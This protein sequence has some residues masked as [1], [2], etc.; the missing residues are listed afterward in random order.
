M[1]ERSSDPAYRSPISPGHSW[2]E[3]SCG[4]R[5]AYP[6]L[7]GDRTCDVVVIGGGFCGLSAAYRLAKGGTSVTLIDAARFGDG[8][9]GRNGGQMGSGQR[10]GA[11]ELE[12]QYGFERS[13]ALWD[14]AED[15]KRTLLD[16]ARD[17]GFDID[18]QPGQLTPMHRQR[19]EKEA[20]EEVSLLRERYGYDAIEW[21]DRD[22]MASALGS[23]HYFGGTRDTGTGHIHPMKAVIGLA[24]AAAKAGAA[25]HEQTAMVS[26]EKDGCALGCKNL[27]RHHPYRTGPA[28]AERLSRGYRR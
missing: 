11:L 7:D 6:P 20:R 8:A 12:Q 1:S 9:S 13:K 23:T 16:T 4:E 18:Y 25:L 24:R 2:Y 19:Y 28:G 14:M 15:A 21:L 3:A 10:A 26:T 17:E 27:E 5:P 22:A